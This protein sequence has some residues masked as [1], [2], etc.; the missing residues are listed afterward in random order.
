MGFKKVTIC[1]K[2][3][4]TTL[5][6]KSCKR[7]EYYNHKKWFCKG[8]EIEVFCMFDMTESERKYLK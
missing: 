3:K 1:P 4:W 7:C 6:G 8:E 2:S 5:K